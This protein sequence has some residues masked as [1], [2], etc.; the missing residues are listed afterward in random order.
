MSRY[1]A[2]YGKSP[3]FTQALP[4]GKKQRYSYL[5]PPSLLAV[6]LYANVERGYQLPDELLVAL[7]AWVPEPEPVRL[8]TVDAASSEL[9]DLVVRACERAAIH[10]LAVV[11]RLG[12]QGAIRVSAT[13]GVAAAAS[14]QALAGQLADGDFYSV[15]GE[16]RA[17]WEAE[18]GAIKAYSWPLLLQAGGLATVQ[19]GKLSLTPAGQAATVAAP[20]KVLA[21][22]WRKWQAS[23]APQDHRCRAGAMSRGGLG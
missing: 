6:F 11:L 18:A 20:A 23:P 16:K 5:A 10:D 4:E 1:V 2:R 8:P 12:R 3:E 19:G 17:A 14:V 7:R 21:G 22:L 13:T 9:D 15:D